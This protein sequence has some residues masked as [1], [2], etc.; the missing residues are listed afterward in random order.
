MLQ[1]SQN[2]NVEVGHPENELGSTRETEE[3]TS[4][5]SMK[6]IIYCSIYY[7]HVSNNW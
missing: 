1:L 3:G 5:T 6:L 7:V 4:N 2:Y